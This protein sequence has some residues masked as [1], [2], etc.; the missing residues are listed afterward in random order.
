MW[1][2]RLYRRSTGIAFR[3]QQQRHQRGQ[4]QEI[5]RQ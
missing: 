3:R 5:A 1:I 2:Y 4:R